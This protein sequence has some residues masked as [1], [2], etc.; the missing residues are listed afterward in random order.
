MPR[1]LVNSGNHVFRVKEAPWQT[2]RGKIK[3]FDEVVAH[4]AAL[5]AE[6]EERSNQ[7]EEMRFLAFRIIFTGIF[8]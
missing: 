4:P 6:P 5:A 3:L 7:M 1:P 2:C 8:R